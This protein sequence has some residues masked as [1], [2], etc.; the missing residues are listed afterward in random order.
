MKPENNPWNHGFMVVL[1]LEE[2]VT[3]EL[4]P[5]IQ[6]GNQPSIDLLSNNDERWNQEI[7]KHNI[8][9]RDASLL[10]KS[11]ESYVNAVCS[12]R[13]AKIEPFG[14]KYIRILQSKKLLPSFMSPVTI[15][16]LYDNIKCES[17]REIILSSLQIRIKKLIGI[18]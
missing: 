3:F 2:C 6:C 11:Y 17:H 5:Y 4:H 14:G 13:M 10:K 7:E 1:K 18:S 9:I 16:Q 8:I 12:Q 15:K